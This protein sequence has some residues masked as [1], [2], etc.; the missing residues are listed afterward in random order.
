MS[1]LMDPHPLSPRPCTATVPPETRPPRIVG[2]LCDWAVEAQGI[3]REDGTMRD[4]PNV[5]L[6]KVPCSGFVRPSWLEFALKNGAGAAFV[7]G[8]PIGDCFNRLGNN[9][10]ADRVNQ[11]RRRLER[12]KIHPERIAMLCYGL[13]EKSRFVEAVRK[14]SNRVAVLLGAAP[15]REV[16]SAMSLTSAAEDLEEKLLSLLFLPNPLRRVWRVIKY[17][18]LFGPEFPKVIE[19]LLEEVREIRRLNEHG[20]QPSQQEA[21]QDAIKL[22]GEI[23][24]GHPRNLTLDGAWALAEAL[25]LILPQLGDE[26]YIGTLLIKEQVIDDGFRIRRNLGAILAMG[27]FGGANACPGRTSTS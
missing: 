6:I 23:S 2:F 19:I 25:Q 18:Q 16:I 21:V 5:T 12:Q 17:P 20:K 27:A 8:C 3:V 15:V 24:R 1:E 4:V 7:C 26:E 10:M 13:H 11:M 14:L 9:L 22:L